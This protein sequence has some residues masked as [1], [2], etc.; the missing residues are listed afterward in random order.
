MRRRPSFACLAALGA[1]LAGCTAERERPGS[2]SL[3]PG[4]ELTIVHPKPGQIV[5]LAATFEAVKAADGAVELDE[6]GRAPHR[7]VAWHLPQAL[8]DVRRPAPPEEHAKDELRWRLDGGPWKEIGVGEAARGFSLGQ[9]ALPA[10]THVLQVVLV[11]GTGHPYANPEAAAQRV[12]HL[13]AED[14][15][16]DLLE[17]TADRPLAPRNELH[18]WLVSLP[19]LVRGNEVVLPVGSGGHALDGKHWR[20]AW[21][22]S[23][24]ETWTAIDGAGGIRLPGLAAGKRSVD[25]R[26][27]RRLEGAKEEGGWRPALRPRAAYETDE[28]GRLAERAEP[29]PGET[30]YVRYEVVVGS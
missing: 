25:V 2:G 13:F 15:A 9:A 23:G 3:W 12:F 8:V 28:D 4:P 17:P 6:Q 1:L 27:E 21:R 26:L 24:S 22:E 18:P 10:G 5:T 19:P 14:G 7:V 11:D 30:D 20:A 16:A 29:A